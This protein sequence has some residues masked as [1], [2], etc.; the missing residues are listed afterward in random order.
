MQNAT[1]DTFRRRWKRWVT[2]IGFASIALWCGALGF[3]VYMAP[4][5]R[6]PD[7]AA[8][9]IYGWANHGTFVYLS[10]CEDFM[11]KAAMAVAGVLFV[12]AAWIESKTDPWQRRAR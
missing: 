3:I 10:R 1:S 6:A 5:R 8:G 2:V 12:L 4:G 9:R 7:L 11:V